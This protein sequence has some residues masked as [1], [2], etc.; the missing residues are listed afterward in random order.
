MSDDLPLRGRP[1]HRGNEGNMN[2]LVIIAAAT[3]LACGSKDGSSDKSTSSASGFRAPKPHEKVDG[4]AMYRIDLDQ[5][6]YQRVDDQEKP[7]GEPIHVAWSR[8]GEERCR[9]E[10]DP[11]SEEISTWFTRNRAET[12]GS[13]DLEIKDKGADP[14]VLSCVVNAAINTKFD[15]AP[16]RYKVSA[17]A[18]F[19]SPQK[20]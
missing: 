9:I 7:V 3:L 16:G 8:A 4:P 14:E 1:A 13:I 11:G 5:I 12:G 6:T 17:K 2:R 20:Q 19:S 15:G 18:W 10:K